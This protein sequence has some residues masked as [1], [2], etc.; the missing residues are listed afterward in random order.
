LVAELRS[1]FQQSATRHA[2][3]MRDSS[4]DAD[5]SDAALRLKGLAASFGAT[6]LMA[7]AGRAA[8]DRSGDAAAL[9]AIDA[10]IEALGA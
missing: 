2:A 6:D 7:L 9:A 8:R 3:A 10:G 1:A 4:C 5:W